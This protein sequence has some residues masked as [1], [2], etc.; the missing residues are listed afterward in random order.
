MHSDPACQFPEQIRVNSNTNCPLTAG[1]MHSD[2]A[3]KLLERTNELP[4]HHGLHALAEQVHVELL[5]AGAGDGG[6]EVHTLVQRVNL[7]GR[8]GGGG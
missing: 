3:C 8:L 4:T 7:N 1:S 6:V 2:P 5:E